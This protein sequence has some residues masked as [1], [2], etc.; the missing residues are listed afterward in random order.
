[1]PKKTVIRGFGG[2]KF[3][4]HTAILNEFKDVEV[5]EIPESK[6][7]KIEC[8]GGGKIT[9]DFNDKKITLFSKS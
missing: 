9:I 4:Y 2:D 8:P 1:M 5:S 6:E 3:K 7:W